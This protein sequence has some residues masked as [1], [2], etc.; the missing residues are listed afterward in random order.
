MGWHQHTPNLSAI[1]SGALVPRTM[2]H[3]CWIQVPHLKHRI[4]LL[5][6]QM[7]YGIHLSF[8]PTGNPKQALDVK[9][10]V[11]WDAHSPY[12][13]EHNLN[14]LSPPH[15]GIRK[16]ERSRQPHCHPSSF[17]HQKNGE[18]FPGNWYMKVLL[19]IISP[20]SFKIFKICFLFNF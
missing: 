10:K 8:R 2:K 4:V 5:T 15:Q 11:F 6:T 7:D 1:G 16:W 3:V 19:L 20:H 9:S 12:S 18:Y 17:S 14:L 13:P